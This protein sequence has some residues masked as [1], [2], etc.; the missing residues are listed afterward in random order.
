MG[1]PT[2]E[3]DAEKI[4]EL[5]QNVITKETD[6]KY[7]LKFNKINLKIREQENRWGRVISTIIDGLY[8][9]KE[10][11]I[12]GFS[13]SAHPQP[14]TLYIKTTISSSN[15]DSKQLGSKIENTIRDFL[16]S[17]EVKKTI[18]DD[19]YKIIVYSKDKQQLN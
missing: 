7:T 11:Q 4:K 13:F 8:S 9:K 16:E 3:K 5:V 19:E 18:K 14:M 12:N 15:P 6:Q 10:Y 2:T 1:I 17:A